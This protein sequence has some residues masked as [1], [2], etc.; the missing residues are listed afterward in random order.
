M[1]KENIKTFL[2]QGDRMPLGAREKREYGAQVKPFKPDYYYK[3]N[4]HF[5]FIESQTNYR[6]IKGKIEDWDDRVKNF[7]LYDAKLKTKG[8]EAVIISTIQFL[9][10]ATE[11]ESCLALF[12]NYHK[13]L[14]FKVEIFSIDRNRKHVE[15][16]I[17]F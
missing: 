13:S 2:R 15:S 10:D 5:N 16:I 12:T 8:K 7:D 4:Q 17:S 11:K 9:I 1:K 14:P 6:D 3:T